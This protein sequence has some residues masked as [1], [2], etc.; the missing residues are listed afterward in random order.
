MI[1]HKY[2][3][4]HGPYGENYKIIVNFLIPY[5]TL[6]WRNQS[7]GFSC[8]VNHA[9]PEQGSSWTYLEKLVIKGGSHDLEL[10]I[11]TGASTHSCRGFLLV[12]W[13]SQ[14]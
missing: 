8:T 14:T 9:V 3:I 4:I 2:I 7:Y 11:N 13:S 12:M 1:F 10:K 6:A 5:S